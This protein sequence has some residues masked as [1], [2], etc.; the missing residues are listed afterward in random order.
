[1]IRVDNNEFNRNLYIDEPYTLRNPSY[2]F[3]F[4]S[5][6]EIDR[7]IIDNLEEGEDD[8]GN[9][10]KVYIIEYLRR[11]EQKIDKCK[12]VRYID[13][14]KEK[15]YIVTGKQIGRAHV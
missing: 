8:I 13:R 12:E 3:I 5:E 9:G 15:R 1:M 4:S 6:D 7:Y 14:Y 11:L 2:I 10:N